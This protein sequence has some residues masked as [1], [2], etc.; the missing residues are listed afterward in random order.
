MEANVARNAAG[1]EK[2]EVADF[3]A[4]TKKQFDDF[5][6]TQ[7]DLL[8]KFRET[9]R[10]WLDRMQA[11]MSLAATFSTK[12]IGARSFPEAMSTCQEWTHRRIEM[13]AEDTKHVMDDTQ[14]FMQAGAHLL[15]NGWQSKTKNRY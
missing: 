9:N 14:K 4:T 12:L 11:E 2:A 10:Q 1:I 8:E 5:T 15:G 6:A 13:L 7:A 3:M